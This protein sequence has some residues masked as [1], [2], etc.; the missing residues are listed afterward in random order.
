MH[1]CTHWL[2]PRN[3]LPFPPHLGYIHG[4]YWPANIDDISAA[5]ASTSDS[6]FRNT[7]N[8]QDL[9]LY[10]LYIVAKIASGKYRKQPLKFLSFTSCLGACGVTGKTWA[11]MYRKSDLC[12]PRKNWAASFAVPSFKNLWAICIFPG[13]V[14]QPNRKTDP[15]NIWI[16]HRYM[17]LEIGRLNIIILFGNNEAAQF[18]VC[19]Y[20]NRNQT[21]TFDSH[22]P[23]IFSLGLPTF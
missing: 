3:P 12:I 20:I 23:F 22:R 8:N 2:R 7:G 17:N 4:C 19:E 13:S 6:I 1:S 11:E 10:I 15:G 14:C 5:E 18:Y 9:R 16:A 21:F